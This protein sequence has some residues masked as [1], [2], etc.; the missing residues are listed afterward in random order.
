MSDI[1]VQTFSGKVSVA[2]DLKVGSSH[3]M[4]D[5]QNNQVGLNISN[6]EANL[7]VNGNVYINKDLGVGSQILLNER[8]AT[9]GGTKTFVVTVAPVDGANRFHIDGVDRPALTFHEY[10]TYIF[11]QSHISNNS[12]PIAFAEAVGG[13]TP[14]TTGV[15]SVGTPGQTG[16]KTTF[17]V[18]AGAPSPLYYYCTNHPSTMGSTSSN[19]SVVSSGGAVYADQFVGDGSLLTNLP[20]GM[21]GVWHTNAE[22]EIYFTTSNVGI[23]NADPAHELSVGS[24]LYVD[25]DGSNVLV[26]TGNVKANY[27]VGDGSRLTNLPSGSGG[28]WSTNAEG[29][30]Y[31]TTS[32]V[33]ISNADPGHE[34]SVGSN[35]Y[36]DDDGSNVLVVNGNVSIGSTLTLDNFT[37][38]TSYGLNDVLETS[39]TSSNVMQLTNATTGLVATGNVHALKFIGDGSELTGITTSGGS[40]SSNLQEVT[41][42]GNVTSNTVQFSNATTGFVTTANVEIGGNL[43]LGGVMTMGVVNVAAQHNL[44]AVTALGNVTSQTIQFDNPT[45]AFTT[46]GNVSDLNIVSNVNMLHT[47]NTASIKLNSNVVT[48]FPR[49]K[50]LIKYPRVNLTQNAL[51]NGYA[52]EAS[53]EKDGTS[54][55]QA[56]RVFDGVLMERGYHSENNSYSSGTY[57]LSNSITDANN[58]IHSGEWIKLQMPTTEK[59]QLRGFTFHPRNESYAPYRIPLEGV[60]LGSTDGNNWYPIHYFYNFGVTNGVI[61]SSTKHFEPTNHAYYNHIAVVAYKLQNHTNASVFN[62]AELDLFGIPEYDPEAHGTDVVVKSVPNVPNTDWLEVYYDAKDLA[63]GAVSTATGAITALGGT[64][65]NGTA[66]GDPQVSNGAFVFDG[67]GDYIYNSQSGYTSGTTYTGCAWIKK[68]SATNGCIFQFGTGSNNSGIG[69]FSFGSPTETK[70][71]RA[72]IWG[73]AEA[74]YKEDVPL[75]EWFHV[76]A[77]ISDKIATLYLNGLVVANDTASTTVAIPS[78]PYLAVGVQ[79][80]STN[81]PFSSTY[82]DG[83]IANFRLFNRALT[84]DE[85]YQLYAYQKEYF[86]HGDLSM[87]LKAG[88]LG[89]GTSEPRA[90]LDVRGSLNFG[91]P[92]VHSDSLSGYGSIAASTEEA[93][94]A[95]LGNDMYVVWGNYAIAHTGS[96]QYNWTWYFPNNF[97]MTVLS[98][99]GTLRDCG[100]GYSFDRSGLGIN[101]YYTNR[102]AGHTKNDTIG[103]F[104]QHIH[105]VIIGKKV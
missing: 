52:A 33:G 84:T 87:T 75:N 13:V 73:V 9:F 82:F 56:Y 98:A 85:I 47:A 59:M 24:N 3:L 64:T 21:G 7:H 23:S 45:T 43:S 88:R 72:F 46:T 19:A 41:D 101:G 100:Y 36:V 62:F 61:V 40:T 105:F 97:T 12:H 2:N 103:S 8:V 79:T 14:Y 49:S 76:V 28:V 93:G 65:N 48:E 94:Y 66:A 1:N 20:S 32:N 55:G 69:L 96:G 17:K 70:T 37:I 30:I 42:N 16:A 83:S 57:S 38:T 92:N 81:V 29:E 51:N 22:G 77:V 99:V 25:D 10:Q 104:T 34:L 86:G 18:P 50:K 54:T 74:D 5:T 6:P 80:S 53:T 39:N 67:N 31:F 102:I 11:D 90:V 27:F 71:M 26:V 91:I 63:D 15:T 78:T 4:V 60:F 35:L 89:I 58:K 68:A 95:P 44:Q